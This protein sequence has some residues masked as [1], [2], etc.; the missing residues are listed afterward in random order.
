[1]TLWSDLLHDRNHRTSPKNFWLRQLRPYE[2]V[3]IRNI[4]DISQH[5]GAPSCL[6]VLS[7]SGKTPMIQ[8]RDECVSRFYLKV[9]GQ[10]VVIVYLLVENIPWAQ[11]L[12]A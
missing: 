11:L 6:A 7:V 1:M 12:F 10:Y 3:V 4:A 8:S 2:V 5:L 9:G